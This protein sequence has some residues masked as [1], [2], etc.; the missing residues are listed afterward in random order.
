[1]A[2]ETSPSSLAVMKRQLWTDL[3]GDLDTAAQTAER[4]L[5][6]MVTEPDFKEGAAAATE[7]RPPRFGG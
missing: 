1:M 5:A 4:E 3:L 2:A 6:R 7:K